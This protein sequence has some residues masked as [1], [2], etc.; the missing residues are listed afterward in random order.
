MKHLTD[1]YTLRNGVEIPCVGFG[2]YLNKDGAVC[3]ASV[4]AALAAG[5]RHIDTAAYYNNEKSI[6]QAIREAGVP[7]E[8][9]FVTSKVWN[10]DRGYETTL[11]AFARTLE[12]LQMNYLDLYLIHWPAVQKQFA[13]WEEL[14]LGTWKAMTELYQAGKI[15]AIG[16][17][18]FMPH[19]LKALMETEVKP[20]VNQIE[21]HP[22]QNQDETV[23]YCQA[24][25]I[26]VEAW[27]PL[28]RGK[29]QDH[30]LLNRLAETHQ[31]SLAQICLRWCLQKNTLPLPKSVT[32]SRIVEN[33][34]LFDFALNDEEM[35]AISR[36]APCGSSGH[37]PDDIA[38]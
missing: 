9:L 34:N 15:R 26:V 19:H 36:M 32:P 5:Y 13:N 17:S 35:E 28:G 37:H 3:V 24:N 2:T 23:A 1:S 8:D 22:G 14:N 20:M 21:L 12:N 6:G 16:V 29:L 38:F 10:A 18:N 33:T 27:S 25:G 11:T 4:K 7:R 30:P 31:K